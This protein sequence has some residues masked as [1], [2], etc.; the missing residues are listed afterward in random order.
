MSNRAYWLKSAFFTLFE[1]GSV[2]IFGFGSTF[3]LFR[4]LTLQQFGTWEL[5]LALVSF[6]EVGRV[7]L[8]QNALVKYLATSEQQEYGVIST[9]SLVLNII[10]S[11]LSVL[12]IVSIAYPLSVY[13]DAPEIAVLLPIYAITTTLLI[14]FFQFNFI[15]QGNFDFK[16]IFW[17]NFVRQF[18]FFSYV[19]FMYVSGREITLVGLASWQ[20]VTAAVGALTAFI[21]GRKY[22]RFSRQLDW[23]WVRRLFAFGK[24]V[25]GTNLSTMLYKSIDK[26]MLGTLLTPAAVA[27]YGTAIRITNLADVPTN[28]I[29]AIVFPQSAKQMKE[30]GAD[31][32]GRLYERSVGA[33]LAFLLPFLLVIL[34]FPEFVIVTIAS[35]K[36]LGAVPLL[37]LTILYGLFMPFAV[38]FGTVLDSIGRPRVNFYFTLLSALMNVVFNYLFITTYGVVGA[39]YGT[40]L[41]YGLMFVVMQT[42]LRRTMGV[43]FW[44]AFPN[45]LMFYRE[46]FKMIRSYLQRGKLEGP[47]ASVEQ[48]ERELV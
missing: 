44:R 38:Q 6:V 19:C 28:S 39:A 26:I 8:L 35:E 34:I 31:A 32:I 4:A 14:P 24:Y 11:A 42:V 12:L 17:S 15:Q 37:R 41:T 5:F 2:F 7:G 16:G 20:V 47:I 46:G 10:L 3:I 30:R 29:A 13:W 40:L 9:A 48:T 21:F 25:F 23:R 1:K 45:A 27:L 22:L 36:Y 33:I 18:L 43:Q